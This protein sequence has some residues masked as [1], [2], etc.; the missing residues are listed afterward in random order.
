M[1]EHVPAVPI[2]P[3]TDGPPQVPMLGNDG[4]GAQRRLYVRMS[5]G[6][7]SGTDWSDALSGAAWPSR[8]LS[9]L[10]VRVHP[11]KNFP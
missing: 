1:S 10:T 11:H 2:V 7:T 8:M 4:H 5:A 3:V 6:S 9:V